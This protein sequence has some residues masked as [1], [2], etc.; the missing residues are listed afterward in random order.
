MHSFDFIDTSSSAEFNAATTRVISVSDLNRTTRQLL[1]DAYGTIWIQ[2]ELS[3]VVKPRSGHIYFSLKDEFCQVRCALFKNKSSLNFDPMDGLHVVAKASV[4][5]YEPRGDYQLIV[6]Q[7]I[8]AGEGAL[9]QAFEL[10]KKKLLKEGLFE[11]KYKKAIPEYPNKIAVITSPTGAAIRDILTTLKRRYP[12]VEVCVYPT[13]VQGTEAAKNIVKALTLANKHNYCDVIILARGGG[14][15]EDLW[16]FNEE[17]VARAIFKSA[18]PIISGIGHEPDTTIADFVADL[19]AA[20]PT[21]AA[22]HAVPAQLDIK[23]SLNS[24]LKRMIYLIER[25]LKTYQQQVD[26]LSKRLQH[27]TQKIQTSKEKLIRL[28]QALC[29]LIKNK[30]AIFNHHLTST[31]RMLHAVSPLNTL[32]RGY[33]IVKQSDTT[34][35]KIITSVK[36]LKVG[37]EIEVILKQG[38]IRANITKLCPKPILPIAQQPAKDHLEE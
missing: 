16:P 11:D 34:T 23:D 28:E 31:A 25:Q 19:R 8:L 36:Q 4:S 37:T 29:T 12:I 35:N 38:Q 20:T 22:E 15:L 24:Y 33:A 3:N 7:L 21:A 5:L 1:E 13:L 18:L 10:L 30:L 2:G 14:S 9:S 6:S 27:P 32:D 17:S 26:Y